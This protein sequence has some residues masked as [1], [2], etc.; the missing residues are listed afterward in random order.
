MALFLSIH[1]S[2]LL[3]C[4]CCFSKDFPY[5]RTIPQFSS[6]LSVLTDQAIHQKFHTMQT[7]KQ[8]N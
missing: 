3:F 8:T 1:L 5:I 6:T 7:N 2:T 4:S